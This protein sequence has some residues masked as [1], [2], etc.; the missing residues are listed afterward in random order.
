MVNNM[1]CL[2]NFKTLR[3]TKD[4][5]VGEVREALLR[6]GRLAGRKL[7]LHTRSHSEWFLVPAFSGTDIQEF[8]NIKLAAT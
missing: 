7:N 5:S 4:E 2:L 1:K 6:K 8:I 3:L